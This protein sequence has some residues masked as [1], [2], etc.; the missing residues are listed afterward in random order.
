MT[1]AMTGPVSGEA[2]LPEPE[3]RKFAVVGGGVCGLSATY[4][5]ARSGHNV[6]LFE[7]ERDI[8]GLA[9]VFEVGGQRL[10]KFY[11]HWLGTDQHAFDLIKEIGT[12]EKL[13]FNSSSVGI[14]YSNKIYRFSSPIDLLFFDPL[15]ILS[16]IRFGISVIYSWMIRNDKYLEQVSAV[17]WLE[18]VVGKRGFD[19]VWRPLLVGKFGEHY[20]DVAAI[21]IWNK[22][23]Q[24]GRSRDT[25]SKEQLAYYVG[26][27]GEFLDDLTNAAMARGATI[28]LERPVAGLC[29][30]GES[31][32]ITLRCANGS[33]EQ[34]DG[35]ILAVPIPDAIKLLKG[36]VPGDYI[37]QLER[38]RYLANVCLILKLKKS[39]SETYWLNVNDPG[40]PFVGIIEH[41]NFESADNYE[42]RHLVYLSKYL[43]ESAELYQMS[44][45]D[46]L[47]YAIPH[48][49]KMFPEFRRED[50]VTHSVWKAK[51]A[52]PIITL[53][54]RGIMPSC[55]TPMPNVLL[56]TMAQVYPQDRGT[57][58]AISEGF[59]VARMLENLS[60][61]KV[62][63]VKHGFP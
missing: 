15:P 27:F 23:I 43:P 26:G 2:P 56:S 45:D 36:S 22:L 59:K 5:L 14:Y 33:S 53:N 1:E 18:R 12:D 29:G 42:G 8:G 21:W 17:E 41:T 6:T 46:L 63:G 19:V 49:Q 11:H 60:S 61:T 44:A 51:Y 13:I 3:R 54:Y 7:A 4:R 62:G 39:L 24:R 25:T 57:N 30:A 38:V 34:F 40:F 9:S 16:R 52:Q 35:V 55:E 20:K 10:E 58:Y 28:H 32:G 31:G 47:D 50:I 48:L 37:G